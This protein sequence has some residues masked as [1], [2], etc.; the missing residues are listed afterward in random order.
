MNGTG[1]LVR[2]ILRRD[3][4]ALLAWIVFMALFPL[5]ISIATV[6]GYPTD[7]DRVEFAT[8]AAANPAELALRGPVFAPTVGAL[9]AWTIGSSGVLLGSVVSVLLLLRHTRGD[10]QAGRRE[11]VGSGVV[12]RHAPLAAALAVVVGGNVAIVVLA[13]LGLIAGGL[14]IAGSLALGMVLGLGAIVFTAVAAVAAQLVEGVGNARGIA[15]AVLG[16][17]FLVAAIG[18]GTGAGLVWASPLGWVRHVQAFAGEQWWVLAPLVLTSVV[19][20]SAAFALSARRDVGA[21]LFAARPGPAHAGAALRSPIAL[22]WRLHRAAI[23][24]W[25][26]GMTVLGLMLGLAMSSLGSQLD[27]PAFQ[28]FAATLGGGDVAEVFF[29]FVLYVLA[30]V[31]AAATV[32]A[33]L[34]MWSQETGGLADVV[35][36]LPVDRVRWA[37]G[38]LV[39]TAAGAAVTLAGLGLGAG[40]GSG[41]PLAVLGSTIAYLP[42]CLVFAGIAVVLIGWAPRLAVPVSWTLLGLSLLID[43]LGEFRLVD[44]AVLD[45]S[46]FVRTLR[47]LVA[48]TGL[49]ASLLVLVLVA[50]AL[51]A[52]GAIGLRRRDVQAS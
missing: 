23:A 35:L 39:V 34:R 8:S 11:L 27:T 12:G 48:G 37:L 40:I 49:T 38:H 20:G 13:A 29:R 14:P 43:L 10:E 7:A 19:L 15:F 30:Q 50:A 16:L 36:V 33:A 24:S 42:A 51:M 18:D 28:A 21:G 5:L 17:A 22:A 25:A 9:T 6:Q 45:V 46:P 3:R 47:P 41:A 32:A 1:E 26:A 44:A 52:A 4:I 31:V 2:L